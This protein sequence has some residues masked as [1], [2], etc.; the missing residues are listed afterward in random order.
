LAILVPLSAQTAPCDQTYVVKKGDWLS[1]IAQQFYGNSKNWQPI[2]DATNAAAKSDKSLA[3]ISDPTRLEVGQK[4]CIPNA[5]T[6]PGSTPVVA[7]PTP[8]AAPSPVAAAFVGRYVA[9][10]PAADASGL[11]L[12]LVLGADGSAT[13]NSTYVGKEGF[14]E[15]GRWQAGAQGT[16]L[17]L[18]E[19]EGK[20]EQIEYALE[21]KDNQLVMTPAGKNASGAVGWPFQRVPSG[22]LVKAAYQDAT[23]GAISFSFDALL[24]KA[25][26]GQIVP[27]VPVTLAPSLGG[28]APEHVAFLFDGA[29]ASALD[30]PGQPQVHVYPVDGLRQI[31]PQIAT[32]VDHLKTLATTKPATITG[33]LPV[34]PLISAVQVLRT[35]IMYLDFANGSGVRFITHYAQDVSPIL[36]NGIFYTY[37]GLT[38]DGNYYVSVTWF[39]STPALPGQPDVDLVGKALDEFV[40]SYDSYVA[41]IATEL[42]GL[43]SALFTPD[44][45]LLDGM[46]QSLQVGAAAPVTATTT[47]TTTAP[48]TGTVVTTPL[49]ITQAVTITAPVTGTVPLTVTKAVTGTKAVTTTASVTGTLATAPITG[50]QPLTATEATT[51]TVPLTGTLATTPLTGTLPTTLTITLAATSTLTT[52]PLTGTLPTTLTLAPGGAGGASTATLVAINLEAGLV[53]DPFLVSVT[54]GGKVDASTLVTG[55][56][57]FINAAPTVTLI[58]GGQSD[59]LD[60]FFYSDYD[61]MLIVQTPDGEYLCNND[62]SVK[63]LDPTIHIERPAAGPYNIWV[64]SPAA[65]QWIP[66]ILVLTARPDVNVGNFSLVGLV[67]RTVASETSAAPVEGERA[68]V[69]IQLSTRG[70]AIAGLQ[71]GGQPVTQ[72]MVISGVVPASELP[73]P[74]IIFTLCNPVRACPAHQPP[75]P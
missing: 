52:A 48:V 56:A 24:A 38:S 46:I 72:S 51:T 5:K 3:A 30:D 16:R 65:K 18:T 26:K 49:T 42:N 54:G 12:T 44:L 17:T 63:V 75:G 1:S 45:L 28:A 23:L 64:G 9:T 20:P 27:A 32:V 71:A 22:Q 6:S 13:L 73:R 2:I 39:L 4:L 69:P 55:C 61:P 68:V 59:F 66:G 67:K 33:D 74:C 36:A 58:W 29:A 53:L 31:D 25:A 11:V 8:A 21:I 60:A 50:T 15:K 7:Q 19:V 62:A 43:P 70:V 14:N 40:Q 47:A 57:G 41:G 35:Q 34:F 10:L 37:Q